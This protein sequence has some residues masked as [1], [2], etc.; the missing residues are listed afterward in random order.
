MQILYFVGLLLVN[1]NVHS[2]GMFHYSNAGSIISNP[3]FRF[4]ICTGR[5]MFTVTSMCPGWQVI[6]ILFSSLTSVCVLIERD[7][8]IALET[9]YKKIVEHV[10]CT[11]VH[12][13]SIKLRSVQTV[14]VY[15]ND[16]IGFQHTCLQ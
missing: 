16:H 10:L 14:H 6:S 11:Y 3:A 4:Q 8:F 2:Q 13:N 15:T 9:M 7:Y 1:F 12:D 5:I